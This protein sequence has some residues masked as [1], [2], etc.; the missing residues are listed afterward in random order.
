MTTEDVR[1]PIRVLLV[2][3]NLDD[4]KL[5][6]RALRTCELPLAVRV[7]RDGVRARQALRLGEAS[8]DGE[9]GAFD[10]VVSDLK[11][12]GLDGHQL[13]CLVRGDARLSR[14]P[15]VIFSSSK[16]TPDVRRCLECGAD[17]FVQKPVGFQEY[18]DCLRG[19]VRWALGGFR[20]SESPPCVVASPEP[21]SLDR[22]AA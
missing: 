8:D 4:E 5:A 9:R 1:D 18:L 7:A 10:L 19:V 12:P 6:L 3:D 13:L 15:Y 17:A 16:E 21:R 11:L 14:V 2:E 22:R 20:P